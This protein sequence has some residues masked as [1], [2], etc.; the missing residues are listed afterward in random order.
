MQIHKI[1]VTVPLNAR[2]SIRLAPKT[3]RKKRSCEMHPHV[4][5]SRLTSVRYFNCQISVE[6]KPLTSEVM[7]SV[8]LSVYFS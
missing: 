3:R 6:L 1:D 5:N 8:E 4:S 7:E 2:S